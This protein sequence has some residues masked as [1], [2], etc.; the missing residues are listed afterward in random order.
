MEKKKSL[1]TPD[2]THG[3]SGVVPKN[4]VYET[5][6]KVRKVQDKTGWKVLPENE[7]ITG[8]SSGGK[9]K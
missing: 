1:K 2:S 9:K 8:K 4:T 3:E 7:M 6:D 5:P